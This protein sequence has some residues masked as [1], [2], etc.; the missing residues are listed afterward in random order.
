MQRVDGPGIPS[1][2]FHR[3]DQ[4]ARLVLDVVHR[5]DLGA[6]L[7]TEGGAQSR[8]G[9]VLATPHLGG[10]QDRQHQVDPR[11]SGRRF[12]QHMQPV[13][14]L[15]VLDLAQP[16]VDVQQEVVELFVVGPVVEPQ[17]AMHLR[18]AHQVP[19]LAADGRQLGRIH[20]RDVSVFIE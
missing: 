9:M 14:D 6:L 10:A 12:A 13:A 16:A 2:G 15:G 8:D 18:G 11:R 3:L 4:C 19:D 5:C 20:R 7:Q 1:A 17:I